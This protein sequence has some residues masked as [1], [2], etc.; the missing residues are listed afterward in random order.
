MTNLASP[1]SSPTKT[2]HRHMAK[3]LMLAPESCDMLNPIFY[4]TCDELSTYWIHTRKVCPAKIRPAYRTWL[5][6]PALYFR[7]LLQALWE[8]DRGSYSS[9]RRVHQPWHSLLAP[10]AT[11]RALRFTSAIMCLAGR[12]AYGSSMDCATDGV[13][14]PTVFPDHRLQMDVPARTTLIQL[15]LLLASIQCREVSTANSNHSTASV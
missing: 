6:R 4:N 14:S 10:G 12:Y 2:A 3:S 13:C 8:S 5:P 9:E 15:V 1:S 7:L 11:P